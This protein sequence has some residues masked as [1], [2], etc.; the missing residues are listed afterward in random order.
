MQ[1]DRYTHRVGRRRRF[2]LR[3][4]C[5]HCNTPIG[6]FT[7]ICRRCGASI[8]TTRHLGMILLAVGFIL[9]LLLLLDVI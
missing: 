2:R 9:V 3:R 7:L 1:V 6:N 5:H 8:L 4:A